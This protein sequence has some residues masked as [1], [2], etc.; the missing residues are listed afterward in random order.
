MKK[1]IGY[2]KT[3]TEYYKFECDRCGCIFVVDNHE[4]LY[5]DCFDNYILMCPNCTEIITI[6]SIQELEDHKCNYKEG[7]NYEY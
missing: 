5:R 3:R 6:E 4:K 1:I 7:T 2:R